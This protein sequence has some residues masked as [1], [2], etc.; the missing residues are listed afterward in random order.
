MGWET[1]GGQQRPFDKLRVTALGNG[2]DGA[3]ER[4]TA[5]DI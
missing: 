5:R 4:G 2:A 3:G 1:T